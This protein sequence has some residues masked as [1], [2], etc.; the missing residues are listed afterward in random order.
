MLFEQTSFKTENIKITF[1]RILKFSVLPKSSDGRTSKL[2]GNMI[3]IFL[4]LVDSVSAYSP[5]VLGSIPGHVIPKTLKMVLDS[6]LLNTQ[7]YNVRIKGKVD[8]ST[9]MS[10]A[11]PY[12]L[13]L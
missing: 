11:L 4:A 2:R 8:H 3:F 6:P 13:V 10:S 12:T 5:G 9:E 1:P 7:H